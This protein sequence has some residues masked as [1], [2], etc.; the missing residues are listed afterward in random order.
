MCAFIQIY[1]LHM[2]VHTYIA[3]T[4]CQHVN[5]YQMC[6]LVCIYALIHILTCCSGAHTSTHALQSRV[7]RHR[8]N[9]YIYMCVCVC[10]Y[11][12]IH[13]YKLICAGTHA[14]TYASQSC[15]SSNRQ[16]APPNGHRTS[17]S[18][19]VSCVYR[20]YRFLC[21]QMHVCMCMC[22][23]VCVHIYTYIQRRFFVVWVALPKCRPAPV[24]CVYPKSYGSTDAHTHMHTY[25]CMSH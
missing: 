11:I 7:G 2:Y 18:P 23:C 15:T 9:I 14:R 10:M 4:H 12:C 1:N 22:V 19:P 13:T 6:L 16:K 24:S 5:M 21:D 3:S 25:A 8:Y 20:S 17:R